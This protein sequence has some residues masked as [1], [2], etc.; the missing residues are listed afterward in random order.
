MIDLKKKLLEQSNDE[1]DHEQE[2][3]DLVAEIA[4]LQ[5]KIAQLSL[6]DSREAAAKRQ[7]L[8]QQL[9]EKQKELDK[10][11][12][13]WALDQ[14]NDALD[15]EK[16]SFEKEKEDEKKILEDSVDDWMSLYRKAIKMLSSDWEGMYSK[17][18]A[19][20]DKYC[21]SIDGIDSLK[22]AWENV[23]AVVK[24]YGYD[25][26]AARNSGSD[27]GIAPTN[28]IGS[29]LVNNGINE[30]GVK[31][32][33]AQMRAN[34]NAW[35]VAYANGDK[36]EQKRLSDENLRLGSSLGQYGLKVVRDEPTGVWYID[37]IGGTRLFDKYHTGGVVGNQPTNNDREVL[38]LLEKGEL[39][40]DDKKK[41]S[42]FAM[43][44]RL[45]AAASNAAA[46]KMS[47]RIGDTSD[48][49]GDVFSPSVSVTINHDGNMDD[50]D[51]RRY[52]QITADAVLEKLRTAFN[53]RGM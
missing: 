21:D 45:S 2:V 18:Q 17:L 33:V 39:V 30:E 27:L 26:E 38:A 24:Q 52:G 46:A 40:L 13:D 5:S 23:D 32:I 53:R 25:V 28:P 44:D 22:T 16:D 10:T 51:A 37:H 20:N 19:Y 6:D 35:H 15:E 11:Q 41:Q 36:T 4:E 3:A 12:R 14:T 31:S 1:L 29:N 9:A 8:E 47:Y 50:D 43:F 7:E 34:M 48:K 49:A 42:L